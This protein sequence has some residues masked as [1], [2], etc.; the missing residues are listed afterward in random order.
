MVINPKCATKIC[1]I[2]IPSKYFPLFPV[3]GVK[4]YS[5]SANFVNST[6]K[7]FILNLL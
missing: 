2:F 3:Y 1:V 5:Q 4:N 7:I 6:L